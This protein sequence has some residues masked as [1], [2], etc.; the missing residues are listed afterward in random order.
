MAIAPPF[1]LIELTD[2]IC[3]G[4]AWQP[5]EAGTEP[6]ENSPGPVAL[7]QNAS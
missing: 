6:G 3:T 1:Y 7:A 2:P 4:D 5:P